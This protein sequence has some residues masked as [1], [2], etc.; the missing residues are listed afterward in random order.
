MN[1]ASKKRD[2][3]HK[4]QKT[5]SVRAIVEYPQ[6]VSG[7]SGSHADQWGG[8][9]QGYSDEGG[10]QA[11]PKEATPKEWKKDEAANWAG[12]GGGQGSGGYGGYDAKEPQWAYGYQSFAGYQ[13]NNQH[14]G[15]QR[16]DNKPDKYRN[17]RG[18]RAHRAAR[19]A[20]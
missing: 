15:E 2:V 20:W 14:W 3:C 16:R 8:G 9:N 7:M 4:C 12:A 10:W 19:R 18:G 5:K 1:F 6:E 13:D 17:Y 11:A